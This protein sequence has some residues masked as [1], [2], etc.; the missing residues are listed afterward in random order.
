[1]SEPINDRDTALAGF[2]RARDQYQHSYD[3]VPAEALK[4][5][6]PGEDY[7]LGGLAPHVTDVIYHYT[8]VFDVMKA[9]SF[10]Q[11][12]AIDPDDETKRRL[13]ELTTNGFGGREKRGVFEE[14]TAAHRA[15]E[16]KLRALSPEEFTRPAPVLYG[17]DAQDPYPTRA[18]DIVGW[19]KDHYDEHIAQVAELLGKWKSEKK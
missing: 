18:A 17:P 19:L 10:G 5:V 3:A 6:P 1:M 4:Y 2:E 13:D 16:A 8:R 11:V 15:L 14:M 7:T 9:A 12:R